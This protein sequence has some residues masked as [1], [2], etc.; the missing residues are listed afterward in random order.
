M[1]QDAQHMPLVTRVYIK[2][3]LPK[4]GA[5]SKCQFWSSENWYISTK[6]V[7]FLSVYFHFV[8]TLHN[9]HNLCIKGCSHGKSVAFKWHHFQSASETEGWSWIQT[10]CHFRGEESVHRYCMGTSNRLA[11]E[12]LLSSYLT[13]VK[14]QQQIRVVFCIVQGCKSQ[15]RISWKYLWK[16]YFQFF[17]TAWN[18]LKS[19][20]FQ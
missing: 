7:I 10:V 11:T 16:E 8:L 13:I 15:V 5:S 17:Y 2:T 9:L 4:Q 14:C 6:H 3:K 12:E 1:L 19:R 18:V 20:H